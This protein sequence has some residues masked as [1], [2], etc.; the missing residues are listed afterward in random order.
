[1]TASVEFSATAEVNQTKILRINQIT[2]DPLCLHGSISIRMNTS[3]VH[4]PDEAKGKARYYLHKW[5]GIEAQKGITMCKTCNF[6][7]CEEC[8]KLFHTEYDLVRMKKTLKL[9]YSNNTRKNNNK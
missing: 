7:L 6:N 9:K 1:M 4:L 8:F 3:V 2:D 5:L